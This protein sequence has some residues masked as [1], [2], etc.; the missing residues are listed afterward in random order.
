MT[1]DFSSRDFKLIDI[2]VETAIQTIYP[3]ADIK[4]IKQ[5]KIKKCLS[6]ID[7]LAKCCA[8]SDYPFHN[9]HKGIGD[10]PFKDVK[11]LEDLTKNIKLLLFR[12]AEI[13]TVYFYPR[14]FEEKKK[15]IEVFKERKKAI[16]VDINLSDS[17]KSTFRV[18]SQ[19]VSKVLQQSEKHDPFTWEYNN[20]TKYLRKFRKNSSVI[21]LYH[22]I[23]HQTPF[24]GNH[25]NKYTKFRLFVEMFKKDFSIYRDLLIHKD[26]DNNDMKTNKVF[27]YLTSILNK[28]H[29]MKFLHGGINAGNFLY[30]PDGLS[31][32]VVLRGLNFSAELQKKKETV[33]CE[34]KPPSLSGYEGI[35]YMLKSNTCH[36]PKVGLPSDIWALGCTLYKFL[37]SEYPPFELFASLAPNLNYMCHLLSKKVDTFSRRSL[38]AHSRSSL[39]TDDSIQQILILKRKPFVMTRE[40]LDELKRDWN[41][42]MSRVSSGSISEMHK[43]TR[44]LPFILSQHISIKSGGF[45][46]ASNI[47][48]H[49]NI[50]PLMSTSKWV[51]GIRAKADTLLSEIDARALGTLFERSQLAPVKELVSL[52][53]SMCI[54][55]QDRLLDASVDAELQIENSD[56]GLKDLYLEVCNEIINFNQRFLKKLRTAKRFLRDSEI[57]KYPL[58]TLITMMLHP[59]PAMRITTKAAFAFLKNNFP[60]TY[61]ALS[62]K[63][64]PLM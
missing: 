23:S 48:Q 29:R 11:H 21:T 17:S 20:E 51:D 9:L 16:K 39:S 2:S 24:S 47:V 55:I 40:L 18:V 7:E 14:Y 10:S 52:I 22:Y 8:N 64:K 4:D 13:I 63:S 62:K 56:S 41:S 28:L 6:V 49:R 38:T 35:K 34:G 45:D 5:L 25:E 15:D 42:S 58:I 36:S 57:D 1:V 30:K 53:E 59:D 33:I 31:K 27:F 61:K 44:E 19:L 26:S 54:E 43:P 60:E 3:A 50:F 46:R 37:T 32:R 12:N